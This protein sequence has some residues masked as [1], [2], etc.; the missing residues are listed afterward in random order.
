M[1][2]MSTM[3]AMASASVPLDRWCR[4]KSPV[5][6]HIMNPNYMVTNLS[7]LNRRKSSLSKSRIF[8]HFGSK[9]ASKRLSQETC[10]SCI[11]LQNE[12]QKLKTEREVLQR[13]MT[14]S[15]HGLVLQKELVRQQE[16]ELRVLRGKL[17]A[18]YAQNKSVSPTMS[19]TSSRSVGVE[20]EQYFVEDFIMDNE[21]D[22][23]SDSPSPRVHRVAA[24]DK[25]RADGVE[26]ELAFAFSKKDDAT[27][28]DDEKSME[29]E[30][31]ALFAVDIDSIGSSRRRGRRR[32]A[33]TDF[34]ILD[35]TLRSKSPPNL[36]L[37]TCHS[38]R[39]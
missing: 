2:S 13:K 11:I 4:P 34:P 24:M 39:P 37:R 38:K 27:L 25:G 6:P 1:P 20:H 32:G 12:V 19:P 7:N 35:G 18:M 28:L 5:N 29:M 22:L 36:S 9:R 16:V 21:M 15:V 8:G 31:P 3:Q 26:E 14:H 33:Q 17:Q 23:I 10:K 30:M